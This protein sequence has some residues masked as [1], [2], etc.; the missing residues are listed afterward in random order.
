[1]TDIDNEVRDELRATVRRWI[2]REVLPV[3]NELERNDEYPAAIV[4]QMK[5][6]GLFGITIPESHGGLGLDLLAYIA[7]IEE[8]AAGWMSLSGHREH[9]HDRGEPDHEAGH[10]RAAGPLAAAARVG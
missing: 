3:A 10:A 2:E 5:A 6:M 1:M 8:L 7:V 9:A 4:E